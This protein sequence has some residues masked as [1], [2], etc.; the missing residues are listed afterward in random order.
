MGQAMGGR[1]TYPVFVA[2][3]PRLARQSRFPF[4]TPLSVRYAPYMCST[5]RWVATVTQSGVNRHSF[6]GVSFDGQRKRHKGFTRY[7]TRD[8]VGRDHNRQQRAVQSHRQETGDPPP[9]RWCCPVPQT[10]DPPPV[11]CAWCVP[12]AG[13]PL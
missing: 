8:T 9:V 13:S 3:A 5:P 2:H 6:E 4:R 11:R 7:R 12:L 10:G 1:F